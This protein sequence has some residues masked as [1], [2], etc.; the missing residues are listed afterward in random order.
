MC[1]ISVKHKWYGILVSQNHTW[2]KIWLIWSSM[3]YDEHPATQGQTVRSVYKAYAI[4]LFKVLNII[5]PIH[6]SRKE[7][8]MC[9]E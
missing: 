9:S 1:Y 2:W 5:N 7:V 4:K 6:L 3:F 8:Y